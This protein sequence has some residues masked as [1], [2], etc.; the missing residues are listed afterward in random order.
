MESKR[1]LV[2]VA[3]LI[4]FAA[5]VLTPIPRAS[6]S[7]LKVGGQGQYRTISEAV[8]AANPGDTIRVGPGTYV[9]NV[10]VD[11]PVTVVST[12]GAQA[13]V[14]KASDT[15]KEVFL[16]GGLESLYKVSQLREVIQGLRLGTY[17]TVY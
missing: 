11:K 12:N 2:L 15:S 16:L 9:E 17:R 8:K 4:V 10:V 1:I 6:A 5:C 7:E 14:I 3:V 13:T